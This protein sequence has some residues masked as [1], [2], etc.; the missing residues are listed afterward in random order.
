[1]RYELLLRV[2]GVAVS[3]TN[4]PTKALMDATGQFLGLYVIDRV[5]ITHLVQWLSW[6]FATQERKKD[7]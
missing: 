5:P 2:I 3:Q 6:V 1:V 4:K 7:V